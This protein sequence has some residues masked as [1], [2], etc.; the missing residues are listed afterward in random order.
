MDIFSAIR[1]IAFTDLAA[2]A[3][4]FFIVC[5][6][7]WAITLVSRALSLFWLMDDAISSI[8]DD[9]SSA[10][11][12]WSLAAL[13][14]VPLIS[15]RELLASDILDEH[16]EMEVIIILILSESRAIEFCNIPISLSE[17]VRLMVKVRLP[18]E[19][20]VASWMPLLSGSII[21]LM[22]AV[23]VIMMTTIENISP[24]ITSIRIRDS[25]ESMSRAV[26]L[27]MPDVNSWILRQSS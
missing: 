18:S 3:L 19:S 26:P 27:T 12:A 8:D 2:D 16:S 10:D 15:L 14:I 11:A 5:A 6:V 24:M 20:S 1:F 4:Q 22:S 7:F 25:D 13:F 9:T 17:S 21:V 23:A